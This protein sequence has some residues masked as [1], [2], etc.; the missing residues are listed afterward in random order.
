[1]SRS[2]L[3]VFPSKSFVVLV[4]KFKSFTHVWLIFVYQIRLQFHS[5]ASGCPIFPT[6]FIKLSFPHCT[7]LAYFLYINWS[8]MHGFLSRLSILFHWPLCLAL[9]QYH[10]VFIITALEYS[11][12]LESV[13]LPALFF[14]IALAIQDILWFHINF[15]FVWFL[16]KVPLEL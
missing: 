3:P 10:I 4:L 11:L 9:C 2:L 1:M 15:R 14:K 8:N 12:K 13:V 6:S 16:W 5:F 7:F